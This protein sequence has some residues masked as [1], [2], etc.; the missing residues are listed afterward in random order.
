MLTG[1]LFPGA[2]VIVG[3]CIVVF[4]GV[5]ALGARWDL[6]GKTRRARTAYTTG[7][8]GI[9]FG[10]LTGTAALLMAGAH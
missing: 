2:I 6:R 5:F 7:I 10:M 3:A 9:V 4:G 8:V 1:V